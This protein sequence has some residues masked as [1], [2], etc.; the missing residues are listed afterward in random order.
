[1]NNI[2]ETKKVYIPWTN[3]DLTEGKGWSIPLAFCTEEATAIRLSK[4]RGVMGSDCNVTEE[5]IY[6]INGY[7]NGR[8]VLTYPTKEDNSMQT[9]LN[10][11]KE[12]KK[13]ALDAG[14]T[15]EEIEFLKH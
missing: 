11:I 1:M 2:T 14:L 8:I 7:W 9:K 6:H 12:I 15:I 10:T 4:K 5:T 3:T 13:K